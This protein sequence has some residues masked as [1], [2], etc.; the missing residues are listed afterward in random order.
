MAILK[1][2]GRL[3]ANTVLLP[4]DLVRDV[5]T[6]GEEDKHGSFVAERGRRWVNSAMDTGSSI[7][8]VS[9]VAGS[10]IADAGI[11][12]GSAIQN[13]ADGNSSHKRVEVP[14][15]EKQENSHG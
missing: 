14:E 1:S 9:V 13:L 2:V 8:D 15:E 4:V 6:Y 5:A 12:V 11:A 7:A 3:L 10:A